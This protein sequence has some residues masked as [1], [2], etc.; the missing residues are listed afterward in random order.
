MGCMVIKRLKK[1]KK[2]KSF[3]FFGLRVALK[4]LYI[5]V[6]TFVFLC[7]LFGPFF[8]LLCC[9]CCCYFV[10]VLFSPFF[11]DLQPIIFFDNLIYYILCRRASKC[12]AFYIIVVVFVKLIS[13]SFAFP[14]FVCFYSR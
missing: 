8:D 1:Y 7:V 14:L 12:L 4:I 5:I 2:S 3:L 6:L 9:C 10:I 11:C 13:A